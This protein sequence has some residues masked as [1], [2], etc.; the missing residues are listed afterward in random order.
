MN[1]Q[2][3]TDV[4][5]AEPPPANPTA[6]W[7]PDP[8][9]RRATRY[10]NGE[11]WGAPTAQDQA[12]AMAGRIAYWTKW[13]WRVESQTEIQAVLV[14]G[15]RPNHVLHLILTIITA[16]IWGLVWIALAI[17]GGEKRKTITI[18]PNG[19]AIES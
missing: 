13:D 8:A 3:T 5:Q 14:R 16:G 7:Y 1:D 12:L 2:Q 11:A 9:D 15:H 17:F 19:R 4:V 10:W 6:G 18:A